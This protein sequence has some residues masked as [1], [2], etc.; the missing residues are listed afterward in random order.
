MAWVAAKAAGITRMAAM[1]IMAATDRL[2]VKAAVRAGQF[3][4]NAPELP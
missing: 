2:A 3:S 4:S 1:A